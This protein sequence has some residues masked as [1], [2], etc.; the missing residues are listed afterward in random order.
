VEK[1]NGLRV[2][3]DILRNEPCKAKE[4]NVESIAGSS[5]RAQTCAS[6]EAIRHHYDVGIDFF[7]LWLDESLTYS[8]PL[9]ENGDTLETAQLRKLDDL[10]LRAGATNASR[11]L[12]I[13]CGWGSLL[14]R[15]V[16]HHGVQKAVGLTLSEDHARHVKAFDD[17]RCEV[18]LESW[19]EHAPEAPYDAIISIGAFEHFARYGQRTA[20]KIAGYRHY[21]ERC[22]AMTK[23]GA[24][25][26]LQ[27]VAK[28][29]TPLDRD[30]VEDAIWMYTE[31]FPETEV[32]R[33]AEIAEAA[34][35]IFE[36]VTVRNHRHQYAHTCRVWLNRLRRNRTKAVATSG[37]V[38]FARYER[39]LETCIRLFEQGTSTLLRMELLR[40]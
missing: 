8:C 12:D 40:V 15:L 31:I 26:S 7:R 1:C 34:E 39:Y 17:P 32:P 6:P 30:A 22:H 24:K 29:N 36:I 28:G 37:E 23:P 3:T 19:E 33:F 5:A 18:R 2:A 14:R 9:W 10:A 4:I 11:V 21:F 27:T 16:G 35:K 25:M 20:Q 38:I 13:G